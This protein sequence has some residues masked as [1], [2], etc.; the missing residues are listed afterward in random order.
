MNCN[1]LLTNPA[2]MPVISP[3]AVDPIACVGAH[4]AD[5]AK[6]AVVA[7]DAVAGV[8]VIDVAAD[9]VV[10]KDAETALLA[11]PNVDPL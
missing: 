6:D 7:N 10:A 2:G 8:K 4:E 11:V 9:A 1:E 5:T 3:H